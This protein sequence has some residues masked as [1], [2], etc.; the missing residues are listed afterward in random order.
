M[1]RLHPGALNATEDG[2]GVK[3]RGPSALPALEFPD[4]VLGEHVALTLPLLVAKL[5]ALC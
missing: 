2:H 4:L 5:D 1:L 3:P